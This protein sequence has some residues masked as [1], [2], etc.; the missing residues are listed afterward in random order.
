MKVSIEKTNTLKAIL[1]LTPTS[2]G[3]NRLTE[4]P[5]V[6]NGNSRNRTSD[7]MVEDAGRPTPLRV[8][9]KD[10][11]FQHGTGGVAYCYAVTASVHPDG[12]PT[13]TGV[14]STT[15]RRNELLESIETWD[16]M[17][18]NESHTN[19]SV[20]TDVD[21]ALVSDDSQDWK[22]VKRHKRA[23]TSEATST[24]DQYPDG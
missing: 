19:E 16:S 13:V 23:K 21:N 8:K 6:E 4:Q 17:P 10:P 24:W 11:K 18:T 1:G 5:S 22:D 3:M 9:A 14:E 7:G 2:R 20:S 12:T 15:N